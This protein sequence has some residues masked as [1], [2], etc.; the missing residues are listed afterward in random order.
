M[1]VPVSRPDGPTDHF[2][3]I[4]AY[5]RKRRKVMIN[6]QV[7]KSGEIVPLYPIC[8]KLPQQTETNGIEDT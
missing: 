1:V 5:F 6:D 2:P 7:S 8:P 4:Q 3:R